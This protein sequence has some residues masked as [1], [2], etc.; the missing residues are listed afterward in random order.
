MT[1]VLKHWGYLDKD[2]DPMKDPIDVYA[3]ER[4]YWDSFHHQV[5][6]TSVIEEKY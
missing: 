4:N 5:T 2:I 6:P 1:P 3:I